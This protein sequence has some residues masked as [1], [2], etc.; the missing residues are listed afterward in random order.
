[1]NMQQS[2]IE[3]PRQAGEY[4]VEHLRPKPECLAQYGPLFYARIAAEQQGNTVEFQRLTEEMRQYQYVVGEEDFPNLVTDLGARL[5]LNATLDNAAAG[6]VVM[7]LKGTGSAAVTDTQASHAGW[8]EVGGANAPTYSGSRKTPAWSAAAGGSG[9]GNRS[10]ATSAAVS[11]SITSS[12]TVAGAALNIGGA[13][14]IDNTTGTLFSAGDFVSGSKSVAN[15][16][17]LNVS[18]TLSC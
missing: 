4:H 2:Q 11:F 1:M 17:T 14:G 5:T 18:Y 13:S 3:T 16:D 7:L 15:L 9:A 10:K 12:G 6:A 8:L